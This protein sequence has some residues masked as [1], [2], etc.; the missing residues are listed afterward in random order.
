MLL[1]PAAGLFFNNNTDPPAPTQ[2]FQG[3]IFLQR[4]ENS[5]VKLSSG[6]SYQKKAGS[7]T[8]QKQP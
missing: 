8:K 7:I 4:Q 5:N 6:Q 3:L 1:L 2:H